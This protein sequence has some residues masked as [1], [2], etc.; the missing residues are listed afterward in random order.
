[1][2]TTV[3]P[4]RAFMDASIIAPRVLSHSPNIYQQYLISQI[5][6]KLILVVI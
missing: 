3:G 2:R 5:Y 6:H 1:M 4:V